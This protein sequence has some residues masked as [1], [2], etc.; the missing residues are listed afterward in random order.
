MYSLSEAA[1]LSIELHLLSTVTGCHFK[2]DATQY[3]SLSESFSAVYN[4]KQH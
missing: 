3:E 1:K 4:Q 2:L